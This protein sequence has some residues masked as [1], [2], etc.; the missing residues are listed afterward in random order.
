MKNIHYLQLYLDEMLEKKIYI[1]LTEDYFK[2]SVLDIVSENNDFN[3]FQ[4]LI[5]YYAIAKKPTSFCK[6][7]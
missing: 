2:K 7:C 3:M 1:H 4:L 5:S 6:C